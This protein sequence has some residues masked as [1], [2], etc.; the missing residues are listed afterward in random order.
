MA[1]HPMRFNRENRRIGASGDALKQRTPGLEKAHHGKGPG[2]EKACHESERGE[3]EGEPAKKPQPIA[4]AEAECHHDDR[5]GRYRIAERYWQEHEHRHHKAGKSDGQIRCSTRQNPVSGVDEPLN[6]F[7]PRRAA[8][9][10][11]VVIA[12][13]G[14]GYDWFGGGA[15]DEVIPAIEQT[16]PATE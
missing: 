2:S 16:A 6:P 4:L 1:L 7:D 14:Y 11:I 13:L 9:A 12:A 10:A 15:A 3:T 5:Q 8:V